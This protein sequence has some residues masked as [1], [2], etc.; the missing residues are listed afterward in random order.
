MPNLYLTKML[1]AT[2]RKYV[3]ILALKTPNGIGHYYIDSTVIPSLTM[4]KV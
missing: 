3:E 4:T 2:G 1:G